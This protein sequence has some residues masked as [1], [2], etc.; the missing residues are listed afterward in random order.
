LKNLNKYILR[1]SRLR[2]F[3]LSFFYK[4]DIKFS[5]KKVSE[6]GFL[7]IFTS[8][9]YINECLNSIISLKKYNNN[10]ICLF[11][12]KVF[13]KRFENLV[14]I[15]IPIES[16]INRPKIEYLKYS[17][18]NKTIYLDTDT[19][20][21]HDLSDMFSIVEKFEL[22]GVYCHSR[23][24]EN[25]SKKIKK[26][27][28]IPYSFPEINSG[29][30]AFKNTKKIISCFNLW[31]KYYFKYYLKTHGWDQPS[32]RIALW[33]SDLKL[34]ILPVEYNVRPTKIIE[35]ID[36]FKD[37]LG[38][39]HMKP[40]IYHMHLDKNDIIK[41]SKKSFDLKRTEY[42]KKHIKISY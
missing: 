25:Y 8:E 41:N 10:K 19:F 7:Y 29:V 32:F 15:M 12:E 35:K 17:P 5:K 37:Q 36:K 2:K 1:I 21:N 23:K 42:E 20:I 16:G 4:Q 22:A 6:N 28:D 3:I 24:R 14:D 40:R 27:K 39:E 11:T 26:Y 30:L 34:F 13:F 38:N 18:F 33:E 9:E 31:E